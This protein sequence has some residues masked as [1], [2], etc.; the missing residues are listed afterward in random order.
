MISIFKQE[1]DSEGREVIEIGMNAMLFQILAIV[2]PLVFLGTAYYGVGT[3]PMGLPWFLIA[4]PIAFGAIGYAAVVWMSSRSKVRITIDGKAGKLLV[5]T[6]AGQSEVSI[7]DVAKAEFGANSDSEGS[8]VYRLEFVM[9]SG[10][11]VPATSIYSNAYA[12]GD[13]AKTVAA[14][15]A[16]LARQM[17]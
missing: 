15:N 9:R 13:Q 5:G 10:E 4:A 14:I 2:A 11:R 6:S 7:A 8:V 17:A 12:L 16:A 1:R 3:G